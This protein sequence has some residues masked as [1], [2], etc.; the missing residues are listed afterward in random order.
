MNNPTYD[1]IMFGYDC[2]VVESTILGLKGITKVGASTE[3]ATPDFSGAVKGTEYFLQGLTAVDAEALRSGK[4][5]LEFWIEAIDHTQPTANR[6]LYPSNVFLQGL[7]CRGF[8]QQL[9]LGGVPGEAEHP[10]IKLWTEKPDSPMNIMNNL[11]LITRIDKKNVTHY[12]TA[13]KNT[14]EKTYFKIKTNIDN[15]VICRDILNGKKPAFSIRTRGDFQTNADGITVPTALEVITIDYV[16]NPANATSV[17]FP[18]M[19]VVTPGKAEIIELQLLPKTGTESVGLGLESFIEDGY[20][21]AYNKE[22]ETAIEAIT[23][24]C[25]LKPAKPKADF[26]KEFA[27]QCKSF[28]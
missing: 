25:I 28:L 23:S 6:K 12:V 27:L 14:P 24:M 4:A 17:A 11:Q 22:A 21:L 3:S 13:Y 16:T 2:P 15:P 5:Y 7:Q 20:Q 9:E 18:E 19:K 10:F 1:Y 8:S 26:S